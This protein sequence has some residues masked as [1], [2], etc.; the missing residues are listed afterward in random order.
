MS[1]YKQPGSDHWFVDLS[2]AGQRIRR[3]TGTSVKAQAQQL[4][5]QLKAD[6]WRQSKLGESPD[7]TWDD[8]VVRFIREKSDNRTIDNDKMMLSW[9]KPY[10]KGKRLSEITTDVIEDLIEKRRVGNSSRTA[11]TGCSNATINRHMQVIRRVLNCA[12]AWG[13]ITTTPRFRTLKESEGRLRWLTKDE[14]AR[15]LAELPPHLSAMARFTLATGLRENNVIELEWNQ[16]DVERRVA[17]VHGDR[18]KNGKPLT[19][20][21]GATAIAILEEQRG[22]HENIVFPYEGRKIEKASTAGWYRALKRANI[23]NFTW[24]GLRHTWA[25]RHVM[26]GTPLE[27]LQKLGG[28]SSLQIVMRY[29]HLAPNHVAQYADNAS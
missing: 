27:V 16:V 2:V 25:S 21:L 20:N 6:L 3:S 10:L 26:A 11:D 4:H 23:E 8:A 15:L 29:A 17:W 18:S 28:W 22:Q 1:I 13:W 24:H 14:E 5:D 12:V 19:V 7:K 9:S